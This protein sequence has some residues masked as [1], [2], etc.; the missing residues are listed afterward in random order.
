MR[1][2]QW[3]IIGVLIL[4]GGSLRAQTSTPIAPLP[5]PAPVV[6]SAPTP[7][8]TPVPQAAPATPAVGPA[9]KPYGPVRISGGVMAGL[10]L[11][12]VNPVYP[13]EAKARGIGGTVV[14]HAIVGKNGTI[15]KLAAISGPDLLKQASLDAV[16][17][18]IYKPYLLNGEPMEV[19]TTITVN[20]NLNKPPPPQY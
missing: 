17:Q 19:D 3:F 10:L 6:P 15:V 11:T 12:R 20:F 9:G 13:A 14:L 8:I 16:S 2:Q 7:V 4:A 18:W 1:K 5:P